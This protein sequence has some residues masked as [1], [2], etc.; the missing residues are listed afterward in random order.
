MAGKFDPAPADKQAEDPSKALKADKATKDK[1]EAG[2]EGTS[3]RRIPRAA[4][5]QQKSKP[6]SK[7]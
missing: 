1:L 2:L 4:R 6:D 5:N 3:R 7:A